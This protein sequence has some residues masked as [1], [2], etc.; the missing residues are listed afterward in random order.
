M[1]SE[2]DLGGGKEHCH[3]YMYE[4][5][6]LVMGWAWDIAEYHSCHRFHLLEVQGFT[7][8]FALSLHV[9]GCNLTLNGQVCLQLNSLQFYV[10]VMKQ[11]R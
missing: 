4:V 7:L 3:T 8:T 11:A 10:Q 6:L 9:I 2:H 1:Y 5:C